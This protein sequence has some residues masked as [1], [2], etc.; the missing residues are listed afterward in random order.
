M[1]STVGKVSAIMVLVAF[2][3]ASALVLNVALAQNDMFEANVSENIII[4]S[5]IDQIGIDALQNV[6]TEAEDSGTVSKGSVFENI[7]LDD[8][9]K[10]VTLI[11]NETFSLEDETS[12][13]V[14]EPTFNVELD[15]PQRITRGELIDIQAVLTSDAFAKN[16]YLKWLLPIGFEIVAGNAIETCGDLNNTQCASEISVRTNNT[17]IGLGEI[18]VVVDYEE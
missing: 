13:S 1:K 4:D 14:T 10:V 9:V 16:V 8:S 11:N 18:R 17:N 3:L 2:M 12:L 6:T 5:S 15:Y 7:S